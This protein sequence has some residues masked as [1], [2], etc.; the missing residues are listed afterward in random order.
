MEI[1]NNY[2]YL[3]EGHDY[4][5]LINGDANVNEDIDQVIDQF[6][7]DWLVQE[8]MEMLL[9]EDELLELISECNDFM[10]NVLLSRC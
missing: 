7:G 1:I 4:A 9:E 8:M 2:V 6:V 10:S 3:P 5:D